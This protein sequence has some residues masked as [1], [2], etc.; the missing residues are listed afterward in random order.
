MDAAMTRP[1]RFQIMRRNRPKLKRVQKSLRQRI[2]DIEREMLAEWRAEALLKE[3]HK[4][5]V[6]AAQLA[7]YGNAQPPRRSR[8]SRF[9][10]WTMGMGANA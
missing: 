10:N 7:R 8:L 6:A 1:T 9:L 4:L 3:Q 2:D 5:A